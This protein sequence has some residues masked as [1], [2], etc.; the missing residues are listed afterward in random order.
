MNLTVKDI[1][2]EINQF[3]PFHTQEKWDNSG[4][5]VG[6]MQ[7][8]V[9]SVLISLDISKNA[10]KEAQKQHC[11]LIVSHHPV[12]FSPLKSLS[13]ECIPYQLAKHD[14]SA[15]CC[16]TPLDIAE[17]GINDI[18][19]AK[20]RTVLDFESEL[21]PIEEN[22]LGRIITLKTPETL[23][24]IARKAKKALQ[25]EV[26]RCSAEYTGTIRKI[27]IC[28]GS[29][30]SMLEELAGRCDCFLTGDIKHDRWYT[31]QEL[32]IALIDCGHYCTEVIMIDYVS[33][34]LRQAFPDLPIIKFPD[35]N[36]VTY[37]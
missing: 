31:A 35:T 9:T 30:A 19:L 26:V 27:G 15:I 29:G 4:L 5:L 2:D 12:I 22:G 14:I 3:A 23:P 36:P 6:S 10:V 16:H 11:N 34:Q 21:I 13:P 32:D 20:L 24:D 28:S 33:A 37:L 25:C 17:G 1:Y 18:I 7:N 8:S